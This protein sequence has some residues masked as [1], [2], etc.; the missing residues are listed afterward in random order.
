MFFMSTWHE[1]ISKICK[2]LKSHNGF[3]ELHACKVEQPIQPIWQQYFALPCL[4]CPPK[5]IMGITLSN[6]KI[7]SQ[8]LRCIYF[9]TSTKSNTFPPKNSNKKKIKSRAELTD[10]LLNIKNYLIFMLQCVSFDFEKLINVFAQSCILSISQLYIIKIWK[11]N[12]RLISYS[13]NNLVTLNCSLD[14]VCF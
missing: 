5:A 4:V 1:G 3:F 10:C 13:V 7:C 6:V 14:F 2:K 9:F 11:I 12:I 8:L